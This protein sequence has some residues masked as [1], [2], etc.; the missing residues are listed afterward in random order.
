M[1]DI[2]QVASELVNRQSACALCTVVRTAGSVPRHVG[3]KMLVASNGVLLAGTV[4]GGALESRVL[5]LA[6]QAIAAG[7]PQLAT[8]HLANPA[9]GDPGVCG[10]EVD[11][12]IDPLLTTP[13][14]IIIGAGHV[15]R[16]L[17]HLAK[18]AGFHVVL[19]D[20]RP[21]WCTPESSPGAD[22]YCVAN[23]VEFLQKQP[24]TANTY[25]AMVTRGY[26]IDVN[27]LPP[28]LNSQVPYIGVIGSRKRW[29]T[30][31]KALLDLG[32]A[33]SDL[34]RVHAPIGLEIGA[35]TPEEIALSIM[36]QI[37]AIHRQVKAGS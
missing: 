32:I 11:V 4:G 30:T 17:T 24:L 36:A 23:A 20:D 26:P 1:A 14:L 6:Q 7:K 3:S 10:G 8:F 16:A 21:D 15:G 34:A 18:W 5:E 25:V 2:L 37:I 27:A 33:E 22:E 13:T 28:L 35:E 12:F 31:Q 19:T 9:Q 29:L